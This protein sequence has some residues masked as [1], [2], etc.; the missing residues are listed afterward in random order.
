[1]ALRTCCIQLR[2]K[3]FAVIDISLHLTGAHGVA[4]T[5][6]DKERR[7]GRKWKAAD[8]QTAFLG[9]SGISPASMII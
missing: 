9:V 8:F 4:F 3:Q 6:K 2:G 7:T 1:V 5:A